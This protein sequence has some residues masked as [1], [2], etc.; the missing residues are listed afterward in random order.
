MSV[1]ATS[2]KPVF[3]ANTQINNFRFYPGL[4]DDY[5]VPGRVLIEGRRDMQPL[6]PW[7]LMDEYTLEHFSARAHVYFSYPREVR[8][9]RITVQDWYG[10]TLMSD[11]RKDWFMVS[12][13]DVNALERRR[14]DHWGVH[15]STHAFRATVLGQDYTVGR[16]MDELVMTP[17]VGVASI[18]PIVPDFLNAR[19]EWAKWNARTMQSIWKQIYIPPFLFFAPNGED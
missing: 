10:T 12:H 8:F 6:T 13:A 5:L 19:L 2:N 9:I 14:A 4:Y 17:T 1:P 3:W 18:T 7:E 16:C 11:M 15:S